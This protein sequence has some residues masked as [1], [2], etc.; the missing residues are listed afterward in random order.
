MRIFKSLLLPTLV[1]VSAGADDEADLGD[2]AALFKP[3]S[4]V[5]EQWICQPV[6]TVVC[7]ANGCRESDQSVIFL[8]DLRDEKYYRCD[9]DGDFDADDCDVHSVEIT[10]SGIYTSISVNSSAFLKASNDG[11]SFV[12]VATSGT[13]VY[14]NFGACQAL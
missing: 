8:L 13:A 4:Q 10:L 7:G 2:L 6:R 1:V 14:Q 12:D 9:D 3:M 5:S 11:A